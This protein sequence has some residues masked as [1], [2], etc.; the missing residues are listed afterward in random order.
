LTNPSIN[1]LA[2]LNLNFRP[3][4]GN[5]GTAAAPVLVARSGS[6]YYIAVFNY[7]GTNAANQMIDLGH[8]GLG[9]S[10]QYTVTDLWSGATSS[11][12]GNL[13]VTL[14]PAEST[15]LKLE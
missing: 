5:T 15:I 8:A 7:D 10:T 14:G 3:V 13:S 1:G 11:A 12:T 4:D 2:A 9:S 6:T